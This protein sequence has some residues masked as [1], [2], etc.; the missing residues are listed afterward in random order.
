MVRVQKKPPRKKK[1]REMVRIMVNLGAVLTTYRIKLLLSQEEMALRIGM[2]RSNYSN[3]ETGRIGMSSKHI[4][5]VLET[6]AITDPTLDMEEVRK[7]F[8][9]A[10]A[11][12]FHNR[13]LATVVLPKNE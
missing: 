11:K 7:E 3:F 13:L 2:A 10:A 1:S 12:D 9:D 4:N 6:I 5:S 8:I